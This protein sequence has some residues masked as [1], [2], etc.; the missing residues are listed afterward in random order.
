MIMVTGDCHGGFQRFK[1]RHFPEQATMDRSD[2]IIICGDF[3][4]IWDGSSN[5]QLSLDWLEA[6]SFTTLFVSG[7]HENFDLLARYP[8]EE[9]HGGQVQRI[10]PHVI[11]LMRGQ[12]YEIDGCTFFTMGGASSHDI[13]DGLL[14]PNAP[15]FEGMIQSLRNQGRRRFRVIGRSWWPAELPSEEEYLAALETLERAN[16][17]VDYVITHCAPTSIAKTINRH[18][19]PDALTDFLEMVN[20]RLDFRYWLMGHYHAN[21]SLTPKHILLW[22]QIVQ[23][24]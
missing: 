22:E 23:L 12:L 21:R 2:C 5:D 17:K 6:R 4:G 24:E 8:V 19:Q 3:G 13:E 9:W 18:Y 14:D 1:M 7:N 15:D 10:R 16:W 20:K 11:H